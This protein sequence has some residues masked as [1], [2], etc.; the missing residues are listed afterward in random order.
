MDVFVNVIVFL[1][2]ISLFGYLSDTQHLFEG[3]VHKLPPVGIYGYEGIFYLFRHIWHPYR[4]NSIFYEPGAYQGFLNAA[5]FLVVFVRKDLGNWAK[6]SY[7]FVLLTALI[8]TFSTTGFVIFAVGF[9]LFLY[10][11]DILSF[12]GKLVLVTSIIVTAIIFASQFHSAL[13]VKLSDYLNPPDRMRGYSAS[14]RNY[15]AKIDLMLIRKHVF[16][17]GYDKYKEEFAAISPGHTEGRIGSS[18]RLMG[19]LAPWQF[20][21]FLSPCLF[22]GHITGHFRKLLIDTLVANTAFVMFML[23]LW[24]EGY[25]SMVPVSFSIIA[26]AFVLGSIPVKEKIHHEVEI[27]PGTSDETQANS[28]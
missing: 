21:V 14:V 9:L 22:S 15:D 3:L 5:F 19:L 23:F 17:I 26:G 8:T 4:N 2:T 10:R 18:H 13:V 20:M 27:D 7:I 16:G 28:P 1:A 12:S 11:S 6:W 24:G 25:Y